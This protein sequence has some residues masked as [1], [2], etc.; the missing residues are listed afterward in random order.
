MSLKNKALVIV[1]AVFLAMI[2]VMLVGL[3]TMRSMS[4]ADNKSRIIQLTSS[5]YSTVLQLEKMARQGLLPEEQAKDIAIRILRENK[6]NPSEY[7]W[8]TDE[9]LTF[10]ATPHDPELHGDSFMDF[11][12][13]NGGSIGR[14]IERALAGQGNSLIEYYWTSERDGNVIELL[15]VAQRTPHWNWVVG[16]GVSFAEADAR[17]WQQARW[18]VLI[19]LLL[20]ALVGGANFVLLRSIVKDLG[21]NPADV[22]SQALTMAKGDLNQP[23]SVQADDRTSLLYSMEQMRQSLNAMVSQI[24]AFS[25]KVKQGA[26]SMLEVNQQTLRGVEQQTLELHNSATAMNE[27]TATL[28]EVARNTQTT[29]DASQ[30]ASSEAKAGT[31][32]VNSTIKVI[33]KLAQEVTSSSKAISRVKEDTDQ[34][35]SILQVIEGIAEQTNLLALNAAI[36]AARAGDS[37]R[38]FAV[39]ADEVRN[40]ASRTKDSTTEIKSMIE[41][42][43]AGVG[44][45]VTAMQLSTKGTDESVTQS[46]LA[47]EKLL[48]IAKAIDMIDET[49][50][51]IAV[52]TEQQTSV[53]RDI[54][55]SI[56]SISDVASHTS[57]IVTQ[58]VQTSQ[59]L[60]KH[61]QNLADLVGQFKTS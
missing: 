20:T 10:L 57:E 53:S 49:A 35:D 56:H 59:D 25:L 8:V 51:Q 46:K 26:G 55:K 4:G 34:I 60:S 47:G 50:Q 6:Y 41:R 58:S 29:A 19:C 27:M 2:I 14:I 16:N 9:K 5:A 39:V 33:E 3:F 32:V 22:R 31:E 7:V 61:S 40:L 21:G 18:Q 1:A 24:R 37:G 38:G 36:E 12:D 44:S 30:R 52:A 43:Q 45:A 23:L 11:L 15:S 28:E 13:A 17:F 54:N 42:L 48:I